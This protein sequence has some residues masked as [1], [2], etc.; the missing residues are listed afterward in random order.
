MTA[1]DGAD[2]FALRLDRALKAL[3]ISRVQLAALVAVDKS[4]VSRWLSGQSLPTTHNLTRISEALAKSKPGFNAIQWERPLAEFEA[5]LGLA[6]SAPSAPPA[7]S[8]DSPIPGRRDKG[9]VLL[10]QDLSAHEIAI[11][12]HIYRGLYLQF[13]QRFCNSGTLNI[14]LIRIHGEGSELYWMFGDG[15]NRVRGY[16]LLLRNK[17]HLFGEGMSGKDGL[18]LYILNGTGDQYAMVMDGLMT[19]VSGD[20]FFTPSATKVLFLRIAH[21]LEDRD[22]D[23]ARYEAALERVR[24]INHAGEGAKL[25]PPEFARALD[26]SAGFTRKKGADW[27]LRIGES[28]TV[29]RSD[30]DAANYDFPAPTLVT[31]ILGS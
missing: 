8:S 3:N 20:K 17:L 23:A 4:L 30:V 5:F 18:M 22:A 15:G 10:S 21:P 29:S 16:G 19:S 2:S 7:P 1:K 6:A 11:S 24:T 31:A 28:E 9:L 25:V 13:R 12:G 26:N 14:E 27:L